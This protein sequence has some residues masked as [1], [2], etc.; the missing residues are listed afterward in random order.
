MFVPAFADGN[1]DGVGDLTGIRARLDYLQWLG[2]DCIWIGPVY[3]SP[4]L[5]AGYDIADF[6][7]VDTLFGASESSTPY[8]QKCMAAGR[9]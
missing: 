5:D 1:G 2:V 6:C 3:R 7:A 8:C 9:S 4:M